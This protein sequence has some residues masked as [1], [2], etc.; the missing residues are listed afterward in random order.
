M[1]L[2]NVQPSSISFGRESY[3]PLPKEKYV[4]QYV[5]GSQE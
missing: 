2:P 1:Y 3:P 4:L 5:P